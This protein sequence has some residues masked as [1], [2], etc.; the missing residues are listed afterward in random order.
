MNPHL[1]Q[2][3]QVRVLLDIREQDSVIILLLLS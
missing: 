1:E 2:D 3:A